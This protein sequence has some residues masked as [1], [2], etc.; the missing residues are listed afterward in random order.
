MSAVSDKLLEPEYSS[1]AVIEVNEKG[2]DE[3]AKPIYLNPDRDLDLGISH[4]RLRRI[5]YRSLDLVVL[6][7]QRPG[8]L[9]VGYPTT[10]VEFGDVGYLFNPEL[11]TTPPKAKRGA[12]MRKKSNTVLL[13]GFAVVVAILCAL[14]NPMGPAAAA[15]ILPTLPLIGGPP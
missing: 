15:L 14:V 11:W 10:E 13:Y 12:G 1:R 9:P 7:A 5:L 6:L 3:L 4:V 8:G 2:A